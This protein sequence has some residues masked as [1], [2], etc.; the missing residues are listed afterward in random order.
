[1]LLSFVAIGN[2]LLTPGLFYGLLVHFVFI[3]SICSVLVSCTKKNL[4]TLLKTD[5]I[6]CSDF[7][8]L[9]PLGSPMWAMKDSQE[10]NWKR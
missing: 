8:S 4:A 6:I 2:I 1:M 9:H 3:W 7:G 5:E 10:K